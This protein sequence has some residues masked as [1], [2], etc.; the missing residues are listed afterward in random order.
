MEVILLK[1][2]RNDRDFWVKTGNVQIM[3]RITDYQ[4]FSYAVEPCFWLLF[5][6]ETKEHRGSGV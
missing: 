4:V 2:A 1:K 5:M 6:V 3:K